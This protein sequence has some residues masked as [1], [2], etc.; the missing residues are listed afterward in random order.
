V[1]PISIS[2]STST[3]NNGDAIYRSAIRFC[4]H[5]WIVDWIGIA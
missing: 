4:I 3:L 2:T 5:R 1:A